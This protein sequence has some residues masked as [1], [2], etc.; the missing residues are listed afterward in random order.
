MAERPRVAVIVLTHADNAR[1][2]LEACHHSLAQQTYPAERFRLFIVANGVSHEILALIARVALS[3]CVLEN[4]ENL[5]WSGGNN[6]AVT[7]ALQEGA[8]YVVLLNI[9]TVVDRE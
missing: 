6:R 3:S 5:G 8:D 4:P 9:D 1:T 2:Y 7:V